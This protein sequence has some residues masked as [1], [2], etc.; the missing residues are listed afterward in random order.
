MRGDSIFLVLYY[1]KIMK[2]WSGPF[3][4]VEFIGFFS[5]FLKVN[6]PKLT[7]RITFLPIKCFQNA[8][9]HEIF[10]KDDF[11]GQHL[12]LLGVCAQLM[13]FCIRIDL[14][15]IAIFANILSPAQQL[16]FPLK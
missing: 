4:N 5:P 14:N 11:L 6:W 7:V 2:V 16:F 15:A 13:I 8:S 12:D 3:E 1:T 9:N 10:F